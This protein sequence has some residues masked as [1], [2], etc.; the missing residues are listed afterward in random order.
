MTRYKVSNYNVEIYYSHD[1]D[2]YIALVT[3][4]PGCCSFGKTIKESIKE[5]KISIGIYEEDL[6]Y[7]RRK[8]KTSKV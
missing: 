1:D 3:E 2:G 4:L 5:I 7:E 6:K 8:G